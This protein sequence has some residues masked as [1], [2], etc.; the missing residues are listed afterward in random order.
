MITDSEEILY[1]QDK[2]EE[3][4]ND[5]ANRSHG[6]KLP[7]IE[8][9]GKF[10]KYL[11]KEVSDSEQFFVSMPVKNQEEIIEEVIMTLL[12]NSEFTL[13]IGLVFDNCKDQS[14]QKCK[15][16]FENS[17]QSYPNLIS[18]YFLESES[19][20][21]ESTCENILLLFCKEKYFISLQADILLT[22]KTFLRRCLKAFNKVPNL[23]GI[24][25]RA[26]LPFRKITRIQ[27]V[28]TK[29]LRMDNYLKNL[30]STSEN[31][32][33]LGPYIH[34]LGYFGDISNM[35]SIKMKYTTNQLNKLYIGDAIIRGP[36]IWNTDILQELNGFNDVAYY[37]GRDDCD[38]CFRANKL[39]YI[40]GF[41]PTSS[42]SVPRWGTTRKPR[43]KEVEHCIAV[44]D[45]L[46][47][48]NPGALTLEWSRKRNLLD[49]LNSMRKNIIN[50]KTVSL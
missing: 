39:G 44:R 23:L 1:F 50:Q 29:I 10:E 4:R 18:V 45:L 2:I 43:T 49:F 17:F 33:V 7:P 26:V 46:A 31:N 21:F 30:F 19:D 32:R 16:F 13:V 34:G 37:L 15:L 38:L 22:D 27:N 5:F 28:F 41:M 42:Y 11:I 24:S 3:Y 48:S 20:L 9:K 12:E 25:G 35:P 36:I 6:A 40:V 8:L 47:I 14:F